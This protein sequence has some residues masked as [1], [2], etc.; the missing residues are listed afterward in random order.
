VQHAEEARGR[1]NSTLLDNAAFLPGIAA[2]AA[3]MRKAPGE[4]TMI[5]SG[6]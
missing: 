6:K 3:M 5:A 1:I 2:K 4:G